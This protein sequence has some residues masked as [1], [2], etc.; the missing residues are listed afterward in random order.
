MALPPK[1]VVVVYKLPRL[2]IILVASL[3]RLSARL[4]ACRVKGSVCS[5]TPVEPAE[6]IAVGGGA[7][8]GMGAKGVFGKEADPSFAGFGN[9]IDTGQS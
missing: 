7:D 1:V 4:P 3:R 2:C 5:P 8:G 6:R 9:T